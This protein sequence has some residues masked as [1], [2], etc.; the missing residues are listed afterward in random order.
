MSHKKITNRSLDCLISAYKMAKVSPSVPFLCMYS[1]FLDCNL[2]IVQF[3]P[4]FS[5]SLVEKT[6]Y[7]SETH[8]MLAELDYHCCLLLKYFVMQMQLKRK[9]NHYTDVCFV[10]MVE[11]YWLIFQRCQIQRKHG[12]VKF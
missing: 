12:A 5:I 10:F 11:C 9:K 4:F 3:C 6:A 2:Y 8:Y 7:Y 1:R